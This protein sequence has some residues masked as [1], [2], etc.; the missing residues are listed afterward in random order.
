MKCG[1]EAEIVAYR[2]CEDMDVRFEDGS[3]AEHIEYRNFMEGRVARPQNSRRNKR[4][5][6]IGEKKMM[7]CGLEAE[8]VAY[9]RSEDMDVRF[10]D[11]AVVK[12]VQYANFK[13]GMV[14][15]P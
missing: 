15:H 11:G 5:L 12:N 8:I 9:R 1:L 14:E 3:V 2:R 4:K 13:R 6:R 10:P 7:K